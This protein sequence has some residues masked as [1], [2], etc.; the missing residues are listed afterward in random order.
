MPLTPQAI[1]DQE[2]QPKFRGYDTIEVKAYLE[3]LAEE[4]FELI[5]ASKKSEE[6]NEILEEEK[7]ALLVQN[8]NYAFKIEEL[9]AECE[10]LEKEVDAKNEQCR[11][12]QQETDELKTSAA[13]HEQEKKELV[14][15]ISEC[16]TKIQDAEERVLAQQQGNEELLTKVKVLEQQKEELRREELE[17]RSALG[18][19]QKF[20]KEIREKS[21]EEA[22][23]LME[24]AKKDVSNF[25]EV[26]SKELSRIPAEIADLRRQKK[27]VREELRALLTNYLEAIDALPEEESQRSNDVDDLYQ[28]IIIGEDEENAENSEIDQ[29]DLDQV[30]MDLD[31][32]FSL[33]D[34]NS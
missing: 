1:K 11:E 9:K 17:F 25:R 6:E 29:D 21:E 20:S 33:F 26:S 22:H 13:G 28:K 8:E 18:A 32:P 12:L 34:E 24:K 19:A 3:L 14:E 16:E 4:F 30:N 23:F 27:K 31:L 7:E 5:E 15:K 2:F 10:R